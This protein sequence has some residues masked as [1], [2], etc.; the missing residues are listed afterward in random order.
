MNVQYFKNDLWETRVPRVSVITP[1]YNRRDELI[2]AIESVK[3]QSFRDFEYIIVNDGSTIAIDDIV[4]SYLSTVDFPMLYIK[5][6]NGGVHTARNLAIKHCRGE[7]IS[8]LD[9]D[10]EMTIDSLKILMDNWD[11]IPTD[12]KAEYREICARCM[13]QDGNEIGD[14]F[15]EDINSYSLKKSAKV[16]SKIRGEHTGF[17]R[18]DIMK[19]NPWP[20]PEEITFVMEGVLWNKLSKKYKSYYINDVVRIY[21]QENNDSYVR[22]K[23]HTFQSA[24]NDIY[25]NIALLNNG[26]SQGIIKKVCYINILKWILRRNGHNYKTIKFNNF[27]H[28]ILYVITFLPCLFISFYYERKRFSN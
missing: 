8:P 7:M 24:K 11:K 16:I 18:A 23:K 19:A 17:W 2:R 26:S 12:K 4:L 5:K 13:D 21:H 25:S 10:D 9:S 27:F 3:K 28:K 15:P 22:S 14:R 6:E 1:V 20:E